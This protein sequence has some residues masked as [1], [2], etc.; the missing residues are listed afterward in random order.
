MSKTNKYEFRFGKPTFN[1]KYTIW[2]AMRQGFPTPITKLKARKRKKD[3]NIEKYSVSM[4][5]WSLKVRECEKLW[6]FKS[7]AFINRIVLSLLATLIFLSKLLGDKPSFIGSLVNAGFKQRIKSWLQTCSVK[8]WFSPRL[9]HFT[10]SN[11]RISWVQWWCK[12][13]APTIIASRRLGLC[14]PTCPFQTHFTFQPAKSTHNYFKHK[15]QAIKHGFPLKKR[16][17]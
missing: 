14:L 5:L 13:R 16:L 3:E 12:L 15:N 4:I 8:N 7:L 2:K 10:K 9:T 11:L 6:N 17:T 1:D